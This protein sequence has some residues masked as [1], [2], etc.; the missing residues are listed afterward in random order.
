VARVQIDGGVLLH[1]RVH[2]GHGDEDAH[3]PVTGVLAPAELVEVARVIVVDRAPAE[4]AEV[5]DAVAFLV[6]RTVDGVQ[7]F[8]DLGLEV[9]QQSLVDH[10]G[11]GDLVEQ[12]FVLAIHG[13]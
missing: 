10:G 11:V 7:L 13:C 8:A 5:A 6:R 1:Q 12:L 9:R 2:V 3:A 4:V